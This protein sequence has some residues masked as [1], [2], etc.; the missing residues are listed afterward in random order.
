MSLPVAPLSAPAE[1]SGDGLPDGRCVAPRAWP[2]STPKRCRAT[3]ATA[4]Q[5]ARPDADHWLLTRLH[6]PAQPKR[7]TCTDVEQALRENPL[8]MKMTWEELRAVT[9]EP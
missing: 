9:R 3:L 7:K 1:C 6:A 8:R 4:L 5:V 2:R